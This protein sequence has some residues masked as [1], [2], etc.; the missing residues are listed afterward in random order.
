MT[1][2]INIEAVANRGEPLS[3]IWWQGRQWTVTSYGL[4]ARDGRYHIEG[5]RRVSVHFSE[6]P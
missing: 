6:E 2:E 5:H 4:E 1:I 3:E